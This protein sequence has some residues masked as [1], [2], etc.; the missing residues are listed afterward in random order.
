MLIIGHHV[1]YTVVCPPDLRFLHSLVSYMYLPI[2][3]RLELGFNITGSKFR[4]SECQINAQVPLNHA[5]TSKHRLRTP[6]RSLLVGAVPF[7][8]RPFLSSLRSGTVIS[9]KLMVPALYSL[10]L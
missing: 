6:T 2:P 8:P 1:T 5:S 7:S 3:E 4:N 9:S 10:L